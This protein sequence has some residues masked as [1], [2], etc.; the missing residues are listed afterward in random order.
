MEPFFTIGWTHAQLPSSIHTRD[1]FASIPRHAGSH[2]SRPLRSLAFH[3][4]SFLVF[5]FGGT[6]SFIFP[7]T[8]TSSQS[9]GFF[10][11]FFQN[12]TS[13]LNG[14][15][16]PSST[17]LTTLR[18]VPPSFKQQHHFSLNGGETPTLNLLSFAFRPR[19]AGD[20]FFT[21]RHFF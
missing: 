20:V 9:T 19:W 4:S 1:S 16:T 2:P 5:V 10:S 14:S 11:S 6:A 17:R 15:T 7:F 12:D 21:R 18:L 8:V 13:A 3:P